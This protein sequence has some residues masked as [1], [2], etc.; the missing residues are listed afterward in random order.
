MYIYQAK[1]YKIQ[2]LI[3][4]ELIFLVGFISSEWNSLIKITFKLNNYLNYLFWAENIKFD[5]QA[6]ETMQIKINYSW[7]DLDLTLK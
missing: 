6:A 7:M 5:I 4:I 1:Q 3:Q 2:N